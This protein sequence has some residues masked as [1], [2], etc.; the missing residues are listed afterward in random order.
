MITFRQLRLEDE[1]KLFHWLNNGNCLKWYGR[2]QK[3]SINEIRD[4]YINGNPKTKR[5]IIEIEKKGIGFI[6]SYQISDY[7]IY[8][9]AINAKIGDYGIDL[10]IGDDANQGRGL[11]QI[12]IPQFLRDF[13]FKND[14][15]T[16]C[17]ASPDQNNVRS[18]KCFKSCGFNYIG[19]CQVEDVMEY[20]LAINR[21]SAQ[22]GD[23]PEPA[24]NAVSAS[25]PS[26]APAR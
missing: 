11:G 22:Q 14:N 10:F 25:Q 8:F 1:V 7:P 9:N 26:I 21:K 23:A 18:I 19:S 15:A 6:Q 5:F 16:R 3:I 4:K 2:E 24:T 20:L 17:I 13:I 12:V